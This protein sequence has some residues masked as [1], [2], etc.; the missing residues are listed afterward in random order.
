MPEDKGQESAANPS[1]ETRQ[2][3]KATEYAFGTLTAVLNEIA[4]DAAAREANKP[5]ETDSQIACRQEE[6]N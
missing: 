3:E 4:V 2:D 5:N 6:E 1:A